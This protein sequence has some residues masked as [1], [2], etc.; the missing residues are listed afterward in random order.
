MA[1]VIQ[2]KDL[3]KSFDSKEVLRGV[4]LS[5]NKGDVVAI[6]GSSGSGKSTLIRCIAGLEDYQ[7]GELFIKDK[8]IVNKHEVVGTIGMVFQNFNLFP[9]YTVEE[10]IIKPLMITKKLDRNDAQQKAHDLLK[11]VR[12]EEA[13]C[14]YPLTL[15]GGQKQRVAIARALAMDPEILAFDEPTSSLDPEL[16][17]E[18]FQTINELAQEGQTML[19]VTHQLNAISHFATRVAFLYNG[20]IEV[21]GSCDEIF[22][23]SKNENVTEFLKMVEFGNL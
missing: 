5:V 20:V 4:N 6:V 10:N 14:Q 11:K 13:A 17:H 1:A 15:S 9:H 12:L 19:I 21:Q 16:A 18:V 22:H 2:V 23:H 8:K 7:S 3:V